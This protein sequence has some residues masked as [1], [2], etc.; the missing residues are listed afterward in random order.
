MSRF[1][2]KGVR[3]IE[4]SGYT[5]QIGG[6]STGIEVPDMQSLFDLVN[7]IR[8]AQLDEGARRIIIEL[9]VDERHDKDATLQS[10]I[11]SV[12]SS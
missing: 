12:S 3:I 11:S 7:R 4:E 10:K 9:K 5:Y 6:M 8:Q 2:K 1:V